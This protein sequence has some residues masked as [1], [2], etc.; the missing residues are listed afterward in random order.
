MLIQQKKT[1]VKPPFDPKPFTVTKVEN[2]K[3][4]A[5]RGKTSKTRNVKKWKLIRDRPERCDNSEKYEEGSD[6]SDGEQDWDFDLHKLAPLVQQEVAVEIVLPEEAAE[7]AEAVEVA[8]EEGDENAG[9]EENVMGEDELLRSPTPPPFSPITPISPH[10]SPV[11]VADQIKVTTRAGRVSRPPDRF[12][13]SL[14]GPSR[15][16]SEAP[17]SDTTVFRWQAGKYGNVAAV[18]E[19][20]YPG[21]T[22]RRR[23][24]R[25][26]DLARALEELRAR[27]EQSEHDDEQANG[28]ANSSDTDSLFTGLRTPE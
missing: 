17:L 16:R 8:V 28:E 3:I 15:T 11:S 9:L 5:K 22:T 14:A 24:V 23:S 20:W 2:T 13:P 12:V 26:E 21:R 4:T 25:A 10:T 27:T 18:S 6:E 1:T 7:V 19:H